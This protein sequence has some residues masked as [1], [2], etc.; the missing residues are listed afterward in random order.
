MLGMS[1]ENT[2]RLCQKSINQIVPYWRRDIEDCIII[3]MDRRGTSA[4]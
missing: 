1:M 4:L 3:S 2:G